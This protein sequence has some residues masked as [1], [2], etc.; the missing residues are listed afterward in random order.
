MKITR[1]T[2]FQVPISFAGTSYRLS[3]GRS[4][5]SL[6]STIV[7][8]HTD[9]DVVGWGEI[10]PWGRNYLP[11]FAEAARAALAV[12][13]P[14]L[15]GLDP[16]NPAA[17]NNAMDRLLQGHIYAKA[18]VDIACWDILGKHAGLPVHA[19]LGGRRAEAIPLLSSLYHGP[20]DDMLMRIEASRA[21]GVKS[22]S[23]K[24][25]GQAHTDIEQ[26]WEIGRNRRSDETFIA[27]ANGGWSVPAALQVLAAIDEL[28]FFFEQPCAGMA[29]CGRVRSKVRS[30][31]ILDES[32]ISADDLT[33]IVKTDAADAL[34]F[35][36]SRV[37]GIT[38]ARRFRDFCEVAGISSFWEASGGSAIADAAAAHVAISAPVGAPHK[39]WSC[40]EYNA[41]PLCAGGPVIKDGMMTLGDQPGLGVEPLPEVVRSP[42]ASFA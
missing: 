29:E 34:H 39:F 22:F 42:A 40:Q 37:G 38:K 14:D 1:V 2:L 18:A 17:V 24:A 11:E 7:Q 15:I 27:D 10:C 13:A 16:C 8:I 31:F 28:G 9:R 6:D 19:L 20:V 4:Y 36:I 41:E 25:G 33:H 35:K 26:F 32:A 30:P 23:A 3:G 21:Q 12:L 5:E